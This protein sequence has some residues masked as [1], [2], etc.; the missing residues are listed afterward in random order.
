MFHLSSVDIRLLSLVETEPCTV[1]DLPF[2]KVSF[3]DC[4]SQEPIS[5]QQ[6]L[7]T[8]ISGRICRCC[9]PSSTFIERIPLECQRTENNTIITA[10]EWK[11]YAKILSCACEE[12]KENH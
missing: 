12:C 10:I 6:C 9:S 1:Q 7:G 2:E 8:C 5:R 3:G 4:V 11:S